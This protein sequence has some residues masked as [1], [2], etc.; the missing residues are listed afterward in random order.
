MGLLETIDLRAGRGDRKLYQAKLPFFEILPIQDVF[1]ASEKQWRAFDGQKPIA[2]RAISGALV[3]SLIRQPKG[4]PSMAAYLSEFATFKGESENLM[5]KHFPAMNT[6]QNSLEKWVN[7]EML[8]LGTARNTEVFSI[9]E[10]EKRLESILKLRYSDEEKVA[11]TVGIE[12]Y[13]EIL[14]IH[15]DTTCLQKGR[16]RTSLFQLHTLAKPG[17]DLLLTESDRI[18]TGDRSIHM[19]LQRRRLNRFAFQNL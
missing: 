7:L 4:R 2:F 16:Q 1:D 19:R 11:R 18:I 3:S 6:S 12:G 10:T 8:E 5:R 14:K 9:I 13:G 17:V 15:P